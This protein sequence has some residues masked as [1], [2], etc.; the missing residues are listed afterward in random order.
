MDTL[1][2]LVWDLQS[3]ERVVYRTERKLTIPCIQTQA[4]REN[5][6]EVQPDACAFIYL[7]I[8]TPVVA[9]R[10]ALT[11]TAD[12]RFAPHWVTEYKRDRN[13]LDSKRQV[14]EGLVSGLYQRRAYGFPDHFVFGSAH[15]DQ[16]TIEVLAATWVPFAEPAEP[17]ARS[18]EA[19]TAS[20]VPPED[21]KA[22]PPGN[23]LQE[24]D[25]TSSPPKAGKENMVANASLTIEDI[26]KYK[27]VL[28]INWFGIRL[29]TRTQIVVFSIAKYDMTAVQEMLQLYL[30]M[31]HTLT[32]VG[33]Y[34]GEIVKDRHARVFE[35]L[36]E[37]KE[38]YR[39]P[40]PPPH[41]R[42]DKGTER[43]RTGGSESNSFA[44]V[45]ERQSDGMSIEPYEDSDCNSDSEELE[46][47]NDA[48]PTRRIVGEVASYT[49]R[50][51]AN[52]EDAE[53]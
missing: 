29:L 15:Y 25:T 44:S 50:N 45:S 21:A 35:L 34:K 41:P 53:A 47:S 13:E 24:G 12:H 30:L 52:E 26:K 27:K 2:S 5:T 7:P 1:G 42:S 17:A 4:R 16:T 49:L 40:P 37:A 48:G 14:A 43:Q 32:L 19:K 8:T 28:P 9:A 11:T 51:Y 46:P 18:Q 39:W 20:A 22:N 33:K 31:R 36:K 38:F 6:G 3:G 23:S 10:A